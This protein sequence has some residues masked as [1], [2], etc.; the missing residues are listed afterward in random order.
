MNIKEMDNEELSEWIIGIFCAVAQSVCGINII[1]KIQTEIP[2]GETMNFLIEMGESLV[3]GACGACGI[4]IFNY[5][6]K[7]ITKSGKSSKSDK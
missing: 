1:A 2:G 4:W 6:R 5:I 7:K 3:F